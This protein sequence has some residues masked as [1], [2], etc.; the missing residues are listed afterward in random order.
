MSPL[1]SFFAKAVGLF[2]E[3]QEKKRSSKKRQKRTRPLRIEELESREML[4]ATPMGY[5]WDDC[6]WD[7]WWD[8]FAT[9]QVVPLPTGYNVNSN[10]Q[11]FGQISIGGDNSQICAT[12]AFTP[13]I[14]GDFLAYETVTRQGPGTVQNGNGESITG[15]N[16]ETITVGIVSQD[17]GNG[18]W[19][20]TETVTYSY[21]ITSEDSVSWKGNTYN[22]TFWGGYSYVFTAS[23]IDGIHE[24]T[25]FLKT[26]DN[27]EIHDVIPPVTGGESSFSLKTT[28]IGY[29]TETVGTTHFHNT[30]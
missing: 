28:T 3:S 14:T 5:D 2:F 4:S 11:D 29:V 15:L 13:I 24:T 19:V 9:A 7:A 12:T 27:F 21:S 6:D 22:D 30:N 10:S 26:T 8:S 17:L 1:H 16:T 25:F 18:N 23:F 20:Y